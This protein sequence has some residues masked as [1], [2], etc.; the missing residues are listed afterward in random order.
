ML[1][2]MTIPRVL[3]IAGSDSGGGAGIQADLKT[4]AALGVHGMTAV[5]SITAQNTKSVTGIQDIDMEIVRAQI[6]AVVEDIGVDAVK[7]GMLHRTETIETVSAELRKHKFPVIVDPVMIA[8]S[9]ARLL[10]PSA[11]QTLIDH[12]IPIATVVTPNRSEA[13]AISGIRIESLDD[14][15][16]A[17]ERILRLGPKAVVV[18]GG[19]I[20]SNRKAVDVLL[21]RE[22]ERL[23][24]A[25]RIETNTT[26]GTG[27]TF[28]SAIAAEIAKGRSLFEAVEN[29]KRFV[30]LAIRF[31]LHVGSGSGP[32]NQLAHLYNFSDRYLTLENLREAI[33]TL[34]DS[35]EF[36]ILIPESQSN[37]GM[38]LPYP[39]TRSDV[40]AVPGRIVRIGKR[41]KASSAPWFGASCHVADAILIAN[42]TNPTI[43]SAL[44]I[45]Y[46]KALLEACERLGFKVSSYD[47]GQE[48]PEVKAVEGM[49]IRWGTK[50][51]IENIGMVPDLLYHE[52]DFGKEPMA[53]IFGHIATE[54]V[55]KAIALAKKYR[56]VEDEARR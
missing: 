55:S 19:H 41:A 56:E 40:A 9:G 10:E 18:K 28:A 49:T 42:A 1:R 25:D 36:S 53:V 20:E 26:H 50:H 46:S 47:R 24:E 5:T 3:S 31:G 39:Q 44:N 14:A 29:A 33:G 37:L 21:T 22:G 52:G 13:E 43:R 12:L 48:P 27:C 51:A 6:I 8:K 15:K 11:T 38:A 35:D 54:V 34:E 17:A 30:T 32:V 7:T 23:F 2:R 4:F 16:R 45:R